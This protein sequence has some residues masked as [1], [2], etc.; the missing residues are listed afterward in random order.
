MNKYNFMRFNNTLRLYLSM[1]D[2]LSKR[3]NMVS[4]KAWKCVIRLVKA[5]LTA[6]FGWHKISPIYEKQ[7]L[8]NENSDLLCWSMVKQKTCYHDQMN[9]ARGDTCKSK[10]PDLSKKYQWWTTINV[11]YFE[12]EFTAT[13]IS[14]ERRILRFSEQVVNHRTVNVL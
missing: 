10:A 6:T 7:S 3:E 11:N 1:L 2:V 8:I 5:Q 9:C 13:T 4:G 12:C 14:A